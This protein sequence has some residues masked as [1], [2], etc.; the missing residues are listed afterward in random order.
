[1]RNLHIRQGQPIVVA[2]SRASVNMM[3]AQAVVAVSGER[4][5]IEVAKGQVQVTRATD[6]R[7]VQV[8]EGQYVI[9]DR[10]QPQVEK[11][12]LAWRLEPAR[13]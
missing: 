5:M 1:M 10:D 6:G 4:T 12:R 11:G 7:T 9:V 8:G 13:P 2:T 3:D